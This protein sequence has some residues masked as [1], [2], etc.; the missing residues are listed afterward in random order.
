MIET[1]DPKDVKIVFVKNSWDGVVMAGHAWY[2][3]EYCYVA[4]VEMYEE[5]KE[6]YILYKLEGQTLVNE[7][8][9]R[10]LFEDVVG[11]HCTKEGLG[12]RYSFTG[13]LT[14]NYKMYWDKFKNLF[15]EIDEHKLEKVGKWEISRVE[16]D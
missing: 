9:Q 10:K 13:G 4:G 5:K 3:D 14:S 7:L 12:T 1:I 8:A 2:K 11:Y 6:E 15:P 16:E